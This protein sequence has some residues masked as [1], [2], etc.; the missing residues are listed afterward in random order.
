[1]KDIYEIIR[2]KEQQMQQVQKELE[3]LRLAAELMSDNGAGTPIPIRPTSE[4]SS[5]RTAVAAEGGAAKR[6]P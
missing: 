5:T 3:A 2:Q 6:W 4:T 1:M